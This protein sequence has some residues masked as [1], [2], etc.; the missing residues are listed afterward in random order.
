MVGL[1]GSEFNV[2]NTK[3]GAVL[4]MFAQ[5]R[6][7]ARIGVENASAAADGRVVAQAIGQS[8][9]RP[10]VVLVRPYRR[11]GQYHAAGSGE[12]PDTRHEVIRTS[13]QILS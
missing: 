8:Y 4:C 6:A 1:V 12:E 7:A 3:N 11:I 2:T 13:G 5:R 10:E 9:P